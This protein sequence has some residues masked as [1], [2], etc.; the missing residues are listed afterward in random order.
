MAKKYTQEEFLEKA[1]EIHG[2]KIDFSEFVY[3]NSITKGKCKCNVC[4]YEWETRPD[5]LLRGCGCKFCS[6]KR[7]GEYKKLS[8]ED[9]ASKISKNII[10]DKET[11]IDTK[12]KCKATCLKCGNVWYPVVRDLING[13]GCNECHIIKIKK[14][15]EINRAQRK[16]ERLKEKKIKEKEDTERRKVDF[17]KRATEIHNCK[18]IYDKVE[19]VNNHNKVCIICQKHGEFWQTPHDHLSGRGCVKCANEKSSLSKTAPFS[20]VKE[21][22]INKFGERFYFDESTYVSMAKPMR[23]VCNE[24]GEFFKTPIYLLNGGNCPLC[25]KTRKLTFDDFVKKAN[26][27]HNNKYIYDKVEYVNNRTKVCIIC[28]EHGEFMQTPNDHLDGCGCPACKESKLESSI[29]RFL[30]ENGFKYTPQ[31]KFEWLKKINKLSLDFYLHDYNIGIECQGEQHFVNRG[32]MT[33][34]DEIKSRDTLK[35]ELCKEH[36]VKLIYYLSE[37]NNKY[38]KDDDMYFNKIDDLIEFLKK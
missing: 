19:Y 8:F 7:N 31:M 21:R 15:T 23:V 17:I 4:G 9:V 28:P 20:E 37:K 14:Q 6:G 36:G 27:V 25:S 13:H 16:E 29:R 12:H 33:K 3:V 24:H 38:M 32:F 35:K 5:V 2:D 22:L 34:L 18:Y 1:R 26:L 30:D 11:Y 10:L